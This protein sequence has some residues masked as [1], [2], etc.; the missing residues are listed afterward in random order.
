M[1][2]IGSRQ[3]T[4]AKAEIRMFW[5]GFPYNDY[6]LGWPDLGLSR[7][8][9]PSNKVSKLG[10]LDVCNAEITKGSHFL[11]QVKKNHEGV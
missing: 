3:I 6:H 2:R 5:G 10:N 8:H 4:I 11:L 9:L 1:K 7:Y